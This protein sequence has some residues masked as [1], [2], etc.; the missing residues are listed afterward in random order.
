MR[1]YIISSGKG[2][3]GKTTITVWLARAFALSKKTGILDADINTPNVPLVMG[4]NSKERIPMEV[5]DYKIIPHEINGI[6]VVS[7]WFDT[8]D[9]PHL[10]WSKDRV[11]KMLKAFC[12]D[13]DWGDTE[14][15][16]IDTP[17]STSDELV[18]IINM[19]GHIDGVLLV[20][21]GSTRVSVEDAKHAKRTFDHY[22]IPVTGYIKNKASSYYD[23]G[24]DVDSELGLPMLAEVKL[25]R[26]KKGKLMLSEKD[27]LP[28][29]EKLEG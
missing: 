19:I 16:V 18:G 21:E 25:K 3:V 9:V 27:L 13:V 24:I 12:W 23:E 10:L 7:Y 5:K 29:V 11:E 2:G 6:K 28:V 15:L 26:R 4:F 17:P 14:V 1:K 20:V 8:A 22:N